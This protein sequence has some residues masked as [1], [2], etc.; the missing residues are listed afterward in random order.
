MNS[1]TCGGRSALAASFATALWAP[2]A[3]F[4]MARVGVS[5][6]NWHIRPELANSPFALATQGVTVH[7][8]AYGLAVFARMLGPDAQ[9]LRVKSDAPDGLAI[10]TWAVTSRHGT[11]LLVI[12]KGPQTV[13]SLVHAIRARDATVSR[14]LGPSPAAETGE[15]LAGQTIGVDGRW[16]GTRTTR[17]FTR[18]AACTR[19]GS[20]PTAPPS[21]ISSAR[22]RRARADGGT[23]RVSVTPVSHPLTSVVCSRS[24]ASSC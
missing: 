1:F 15:T 23:G 12:N 10:K 14:L 4:E 6:V 5:G 9:L 17:R 7:P 13:L 11:K 19:F 21:S 18:C 3:L 22:V 20:R 16:P 2:D 24:A 8:E